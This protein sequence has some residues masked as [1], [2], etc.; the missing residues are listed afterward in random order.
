[1]TKPMPR[2]DALRQDFTTIVASWAK[3][4]AQSKTEF[5]RDSAILRFELA[6][7]VGWKLLQS[8]L[9]E[10]GYEVNSP[11]QAFQRAFAMGWASDEEI[12]D[13]IIRARNNAVH[14]YREAD[15]EAL[16]K[17]LKRFLQAFEQLLKTIP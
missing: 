5:T 8:V 14:I 4:L 12:W 17:N 10:Q 11:R 3:S 7:E 16:F 6:Y 13:D 9:R 1:M 2:G 15:A